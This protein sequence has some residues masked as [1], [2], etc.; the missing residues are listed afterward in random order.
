MA[1][2]LYFHD[3][4]NA[5]TGTFPTTEQSTLTAHD[6]F[7]AQNV[8]HM[9]GTLIGTAQVTKTFTITENVAAEGVQFY[10]TRFISQFPLN[11]TGLAANTWTYNFS[12]RQSN[13]SSVN[14]YPTLNIPDDTLVPMCAYVWRPSTGAKVGNIFDGNATGFVNLGDEGTQ[15]INQV[16]QHGSFTGSAVAS[17]AVGDVIVFEAWTG[18]STRSTDAADLQYMFDGTT[19][20]TTD[21]ATVSNHASFIETPQ[22]I[23][24]ILP[25]TTMTNTNTLSYANKFITKV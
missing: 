16:A 19:V 13:L 18:V 17:A 8:N 23:V 2:R 24:F 3:A 14:V 15:N 11:Q 4:T 25:E 10:V 9:M 6:N 5:L 22:D 20:N 7:E 12:C 1:T 21:A